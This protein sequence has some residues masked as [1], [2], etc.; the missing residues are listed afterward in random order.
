LNPGSTLVTKFEQEGTPR[1][2][3]SE[4][5]LVLYRVAQEALSNAWHH[6][7]ATSIT[8]S[9]AFEETHVTI[10]VRDNGQGFAAPQRA[11][12][13]SDTGHFGLMGMYERA[14]LIGAHLQIRS[15]PNTGTT[16][17]IRVPV[18]PEDAS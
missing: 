12:D 8:L 3:A 1:R 9:I 15:A 17:I 16:V 13:L 14:S 4:R 5:E 2:L 18:T 6:S 7:G 11:V 10:T